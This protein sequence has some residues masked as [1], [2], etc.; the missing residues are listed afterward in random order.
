MRIPSPGL[1]ID[2]HVHSTAS[3]GTLSPAEVV[4]AAAREGLDVLALTDHDTLA[5]WDEAFAACPPGLTVVGGLE[6]SCVHKV[7]G[8]PPIS[9]HLLGYLV[10]PRHRGLAAELGRLRADRSRRGERIVE[11]LVAAGYPISWD[12]VLEFADGGSVG[13]PH[14][15]RALVE[16]GI[17]A[18][19]DEAFVELVSAT[20]PFYVRKADLDAVAG[21]QL[22][23][24]A[25]GVSVFAHP[26]AG[27]RGRIVDEAAI[28]VLAE[29]G[30]AG[31]EV[32]HPDHL[33]AD[34]EHLRRLAAD[35][36][37]LPTGSSDFH[38]ANKVN[39]LGQHT[40]EASVYE[41]LVSLACGS[42]PY[43]G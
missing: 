12:R 10:D 2:L 20:G 4:G 37:L 28:S 3:D 32:D 27:R 13:R 21:V 38:G 16:A 9:V 26:A 40:T 43:V 36:H 15:G 23:A 18:S 11:K 14:V 6:L 41:E 1:R 22:I 30:M 42:R 17:V 25:G 33:P 5:G 31:I 39:R 24:A 34:R 35:F 29:A 19:V 7:T 8:Q